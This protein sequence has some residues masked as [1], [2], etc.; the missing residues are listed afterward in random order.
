MIVQYN[1]DATTD[2][3][4]ATMPSGQNY[5]TAFGKFFR[6]SFTGGLYGNAAAIS[7]SMEPQTMR[8]QFSSTGIVENAGDWHA[9]PM[10]GDTF[11]RF[12]NEAGTIQIKFS[13][14]PGDLDIV[15]VQLSPIA[16]PWHADFVDGGSLHAG[17]GQRRINIQHSR[18]KSSGSML[19]QLASN[20]AKTALTGAP[21]RAVTT[22]FIRI[23]TDGATW[24]RCRQG[25]WHRRFRPENRCDWPAAI[26]RR[27]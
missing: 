17:F 19:R 18:L 12:F 8:L 10:P 20:T 1:I 14:D 9:E 16:S 15:S 25:P 23:S 21:R 6:V 24:G 11:I 26:S 5:S 4:T 3:Q 7:A 27:I 22:C 2:W 13:I